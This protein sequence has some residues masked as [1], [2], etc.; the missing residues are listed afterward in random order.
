MYIY[1]TSLFPI[2]RIQ[3]IDDSNYRYTYNEQA[4]CLQLMWGYR[5]AFPLRILENGQLSSDLLLHHLKIIK[6]NMPN[7]KQ[8]KKSSYGYGHESE[9]GNKEY[10]ILFSI[11][12]DFST[13][14]QL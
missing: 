7:I 11:E 12:F 13:F 1:T 9:K 8:R 2:P 4:I 3:N 14:F 10:Q 6:R 5:R